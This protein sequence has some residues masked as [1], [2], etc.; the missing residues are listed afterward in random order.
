MVT[1]TFSAFIKACP[2]R[3]IFC[4]LCF[5]SAAFVCILAF[6]PLFLGSASMAGLASAIFPELPCLHRS[7]CAWSYSIVQDR[8]AELFHSW[9]DQELLERAIFAEATRTAML[10]YDERKIRAAASAPVSH[11]LS[12]CQPRK[13]KMRTS[14][15]AF[16]FLTRGPLPFLPLWN[17][18]FRGHEHQYNIYVHL[19][20]FRVGVFDRKSAGVFWGRLIPPGLTER[21]APSLAA[22]S[23]RLLAN[24]LLDDPD[25]QFFA[26][27]SDRCIPLV[28]FRNVYDHV[29]ASKKSF[30]EILKDEPTLAGRYASRGSEAAMLPE[31]PFSSFRVGSQ[32]FVLNHK[33]AAMV[34]SDNKIWSKLSLPCANANACYAEEH[35]FPTLIDMEDGKCA[36]G[37]T[38]TN[39]D[40]SVRSAD[41]AHPRMYRQEEVTG[42]LIMTLRRNGTFLFA[43]KFGDDCLKPL[44]QLAPF[45][46]G[47]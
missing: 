10:K 28:S 3:L 36:T 42:E 33:H 19:D 22:A 16:L 25:N 29:M 43:R 27:L 31:V 15:I 30:I 11:E 24:A 46:Y 7:S 13:G 47:D 38:L 20:P 35:Y 44:L 21:G 34:V 45:I 39:V 32:F 41:G 4:F 9:S 23:R 2:M 26:V 6:Y 8:G 5:A 40:W 18:F 12:A 1:S 14:K 17:L 37:F